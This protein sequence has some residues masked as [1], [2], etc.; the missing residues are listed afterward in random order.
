MKA[1]SVVIIDDSELDT[2]VVKK[3]LSDINEIGDVTI[4]RDPQEALEVIV[5]DFNT[6]VKSPDLIFLDIMMPE[7]D[8]FEWLDELED[9]VNE[10]FKSLIFIDIV[11]LFVH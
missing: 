1:L 6:N 7:L 4:F 5:R 9:L 11:G 8:G 3:T 2:L 10:N